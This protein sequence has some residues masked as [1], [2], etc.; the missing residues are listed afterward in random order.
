MTPTDKGLLDLKP[1]QIRY[2]DRLWEKAIELAGDETCERNARNS[3]IGWRY[4]KACNRASE[5]S[6]RNPA[7]QWRLENER[8]YGDIMA[9]GITYRSEGI[10]F[11]PDPGWYGTPIDWR[12]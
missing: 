6:W 10:L 8:L 1:N 3:R 2:A 12:D 5:F 9:L 4:W 11:T 7:S